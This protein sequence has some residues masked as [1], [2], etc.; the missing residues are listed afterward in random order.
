MPNLKHIGRLKNNKRKLVV[1]YR[2]IPND[3]YNALVVFTD[4]LPSD[5]HD[6]LIK[7]VESAVGQSAY[8]LS[9]AMDRTFLPDG[10]RMLIGFH[11]TG[12][13]FKIPTKEVEMTPNITTAIGLDELNTIIAQQEG[14]GLEDLAV[15]P[16]ERAQKQAA[17]AAAAKVEPSPTTVAEENLTTEELARKLRGQADA[18]YKEA[19]RLREV[20]EN[21]SPVKKK[22]ATVSEE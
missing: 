13:L 4:S 20:A 9:E 11:Q 15:K 14:V 1:A 7:L 3:P 19:K 16:S 5:E 12:R 6:T 22:S 10:R 21:L 2:T 8:E 18:M 17:D